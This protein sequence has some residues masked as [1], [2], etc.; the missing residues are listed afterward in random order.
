MRTMIGILAVLLVTGPVSC[1]GAQAGHL[2]SYC[3][4]SAPMSQVDYNSWRSELDGDQVVPPT[5]STGSAAL[6]IVHNFDWPP[7]TGAWSFS[8]SYAGLS[9]P[10]TGAYIRWGRPG[11]NGPLAF[12]LESGFFPSE[13]GGGVTFPPEMMGSFDSDS[14]YV[15]VSTEMYP[16]GEVRGHFWDTTDLPAERLS[17]GLI[18]SLFR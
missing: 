6:D 8:I 14:L 18:R 13:D 17:W 2:N 12:T 9:S 1:R 4:L 7:P 11:A 16:D 3:W 5:A 15:V 10:V